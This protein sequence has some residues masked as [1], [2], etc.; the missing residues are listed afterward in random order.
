MGIIDSTK[1]GLGSWITT[2]LRRQYGDP[3]VAVPGTKPDVLWII[4]LAYGAILGGTFAGLMLWAFFYQNCRWET[5]GY[6]PSL[7]TCGFSQGNV[8]SQENPYAK[9]IVS[10]G[11]DVRV[12]YAYTGRGLEDF[13]A[14][15]KTCQIIY[16]HFDF[17]SWDPVKNVTNPKSL[18]GS[19]VSFNYQV[20]SPLQYSYP[21]MVCGGV[22]V[23]VFATGALPATSNVGG[24]IFSSSS[25]QGIQATQQNTTFFD[26]ISA[27]IDRMA[28]NLE[29]P[30]SA[31]VVEYTAVVRS[32]SLSILI[33]DDGRAWNYRSLLNY[34]LGN[35]EYRRQPSTQSGLAS[36]SVDD[37]YGLMEAAVRDVT[38][39]LPVPSGPI[40]DTLTA[41]VQT[42][43]ATQNV[44]RCYVCG[45]RDVF[46]AFVTAFPMASSLNTILLVL[47]AAVVWRF[48]PQA[49]GAV[50]GVKA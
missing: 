44:Y 26:V 41:E 21:K 10:Q 36:S 14:N 28:Y 12:K 25:L 18:K 38:S 3:N 5:R 48:S 4:T 40:A 34:V 33:Y 9:G 23:T 22:N 7:K 29:T 31:A 35:T 43:L 8:T 37:V 1:R 19:V 6:D 17:L 32:F 45:S 27:G 24:G 15:G 13:W 2:K 20:G 50:D 16:D 46:A 47:V 11:N 30:G 39:T 42:Y 49:Q